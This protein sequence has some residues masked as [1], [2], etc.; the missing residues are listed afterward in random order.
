[1]EGLKK[2]STNLR[3]PY[4]PTEIRTEDLP[5]GSVVK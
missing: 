2:T 3:I 4:V 5:S 1:M